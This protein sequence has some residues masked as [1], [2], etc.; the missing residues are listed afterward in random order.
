MI[1]NIL[2]HLTPLRIRVRSRNLRALSNLS[3]F[4]IIML[5]V[6]AII[7][8]IVSMIISKKKPEWNG[9][10]NKIITFA[11]MILLMALVI[12]LL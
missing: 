3:A 7:S 11:V 12:F 8:V 5:V 9:T 4:Q 10:I 2:S 6:A 1:T